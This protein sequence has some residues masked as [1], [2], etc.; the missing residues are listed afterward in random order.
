MN[1]KL[2][3]K[4]EPIN[5]NIISETETVGDYKKNEPTDEEIEKAGDDAVQMIKEAMKEYKKEN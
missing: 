5:N 2:N 1:E 4:E 3:F